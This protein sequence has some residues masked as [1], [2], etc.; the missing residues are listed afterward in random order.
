MIGLT[1]TPA[2]FIERDTFRLFGC[3]SNVPTYLYDYPQVVK[4]RFLVDFSLY[5]AHTSF[6]RIGIKGLDLSEEDR[7]ALAEQGIDADTL[8]YEGTEIEIEVSNRDT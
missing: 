8:N 2:N 7:N 5:Q 3:G 6:Q 1:A 4:E